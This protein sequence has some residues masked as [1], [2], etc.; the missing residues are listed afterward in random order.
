MKGKTQVK[1]AN[2]EN[3]F[4]EIMNLIHKIHF[5]FKDSLV[6]GNAYFLNKRVYLK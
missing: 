6:K 1:L 3:K 2:Q 5:I 4:F